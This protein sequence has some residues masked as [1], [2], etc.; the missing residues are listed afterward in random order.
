MSDISFSIDDC[1]KELDF[2]ASI[3]PNHKPYYKSK[4][5]IES[6]AWFATLKRR[7]NQEKGEYGVLHIEQILRSCDQHYQTSVEN[8]DYD[9]LKM[10]SL[11]L[12]KSLV[13][14]DNLIQTYGDQP[15]VAKD[16]RKCKE[17]VL[18]IHQDIDE[19]MMGSVNV[20]KE[21][22]SKE[23]INKDHHDEPILNE[24][25]TSEE[26]VSL[27]VPPKVSFFNTEGVK[28]ILSQNKSGK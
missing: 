13:G 8:D 14:F 16:Y 10:L 4:T 7:W 3:P 17:L 11:A 24:D 26:M 12:K 23:G 5:T 28:F 18:E 21:N 19:A 25:E 9:T 22:I 2:V 6:K 27:P 15:E 20:S 1:I